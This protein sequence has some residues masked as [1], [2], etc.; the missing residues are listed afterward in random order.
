MFHLWRCKGGTTRVLE[1]ANRNS[2]LCIPSQHAHRHAHVYVCA[3]FDTRFWLWLEIQQMTLR[4]FEHND[5]AWSDPST[6][7]GGTLKFASL[8]TCCFVTSNGEAWAR[9]SPKPEFSHNFFDSSY[10]SEKQQYNNLWSTIIF[11]R[12]LA[13]SCSTGAQRS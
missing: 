7:K 9:I 4:D 6:G 10:I 2:F 13:V 8:S 1:S 3:D 11:I 5:S 12:K